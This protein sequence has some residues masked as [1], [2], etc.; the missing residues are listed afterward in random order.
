MLE[1]LSIILEA[2]LLLATIAA[3]PVA[4][5][6]YREPSSRHLPPR[7]RRLVTWTGF[8]V[9]IVALASLWW[10]AF[11]GMVVEFLSRRWLHLGEKEVPLWSAA[12]ALPLQ[13]MSAFFI[14]R[15]LAGARPYQLGFSRSH[16]KSDIVFGT[17]VWFGVTPVVFLIN[18]LAEMLHASYSGQELPKH[19]LTS[20]LE[21]QPTLPQWAVVLFQAVILGPFFEEFVYRGI[22]QP[23]IVK[24]PSAGPII[25]VVAI[26]LASLSWLSEGESQSGGPLVF[27][28]CMIPGYFLIGFL[29]QR[30]L[31]GSAAPLAIYSTALLFAAS[32]SNVWPSPIALF[33]LGLALGFLAYRT[34]SL[35]GPILVHALFNSVTCLALALQALQAGPE[36]KGSEVTSAAWRALATSTSTTNPGS[37]LPRRR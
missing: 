2:W 17:W 31:L 23:W 7:R 29:C 22:I 34:Q 15:T 27:V 37:W 32:H 30:R 1:S 10:I 6:L 25:L 21:N 3:F 14:L 12:L 24:R 9:F 13:I 8:E 18:A 4:T 16:W 26:A 33:F 19:P 5:M 20:I 11:F 35:L 28:L 36:T